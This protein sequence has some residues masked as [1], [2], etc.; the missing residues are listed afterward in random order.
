MILLICVISF[1]SLQ[2]KSQC[3]LD[4]I[5]GFSSTQE[6]KQ[7]KVRIL[8]LEYLLFYSYRGFN[9]ISACSENRDGT[10]SQSVAP[11]GP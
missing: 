5:I 9:V 6:P 7:I 2:V 10:A 8:S 3:Y 1:V 4:G 11:S